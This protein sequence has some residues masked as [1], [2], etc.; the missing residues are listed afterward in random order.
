M[1]ILMVCGMGNIKDIRG[2]L[3]R[4]MVFLSLNFNPTTQNM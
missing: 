1:V 2:I 3:P 4:L